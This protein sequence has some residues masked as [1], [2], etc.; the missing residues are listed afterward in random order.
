VLQQQPVHPNFDTETGTPLNNQQQF[1]SPKPEATIPVINTEPVQTIEDA[2]ANVKNY[3]EWNIFKEHLNHD[4]IVKSLIAENSEYV[5]L[6]NMLD[7]LDKRIETVW[8][9]PALTFEQKF[10]KIKDIGLERSVVRATTNS[11]NVEK[12]IS[13][14][15]TIVL[16]AKRSVEEKIQNLD[17]ALYKVTTDKEKITDTSYI[18]KAIEERTKVQLELLNISRSIVDLYKSIDTL[19]VDEIAELDRKLPSSNAFINDMVKPIGTQIFTPTNTAALANKLMRALQENSV[20]ASQLEESVNAVID[21]LFELCDKDEEIIRYQQNMINML[22][23]HRVEDVIICNTLLKKVLRLYVAADNTGRSATA[24]TWSGICSRRQNSLLVDLTGRAK[25]REYGITPMRLDD[26]MTSRP[27]QQFLCVESDHIPAP[28]ELQKIVEQLKSRLNYYPYVNVIMAPEDT[29][30]IQQLSEEALC[31]HYIT[32]CSTTSI[33]VMK[34]VVANHTTKNIARKLVTID[35]PV[36]PLMIADSIGIN[37]PVKI[38]TLPA[39]PAIRA[40]SLRHD[41][42]YEYTDVQKIFEEAFR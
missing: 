24:I 39:I 27:E 38:V 26:F 5:G 23:A 33:R 34:D 31:I 25:F 12:V 42:P 6:I 22:K 16:S 8:R 40:C 4:S 1:Y 29:N 32:D 20:V 15:S 2:M 13:I 7:V 3:E 28:E 19:V 9:D 14:I 41:R 18:D 17:V 11:Q 21:N 35:T 36:S 10:D 30:G 37:Q